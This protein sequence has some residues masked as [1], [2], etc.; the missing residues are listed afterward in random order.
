M[1]LL[2]WAHLLDRVKHW[3]VIWLSHMAKA[4]GVPPIK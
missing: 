4:R 1:P 2:E 3:S